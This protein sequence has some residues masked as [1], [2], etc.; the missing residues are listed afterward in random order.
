M[1][2]K[3]EKMARDLRLCIGQNVARLRM[4]HGLSRV[5]LGVRT[6]L[7]WRHVQRIEAGEVNV[8]LSTLARLGAALNVEPTALMVKPSAR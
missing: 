3:M 2:K 8:T 5:E 4:K 6:G 7:H 1:T